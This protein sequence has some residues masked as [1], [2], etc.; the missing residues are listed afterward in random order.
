MHLVL[1]I[2]SRAYLGNPKLPTIFYQLVEVYYQVQKF[3]GNERILSTTFPELALTVKQVVAA[4]QIQ[5]L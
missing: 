4:S 3:T 2:A 1:A 5:K